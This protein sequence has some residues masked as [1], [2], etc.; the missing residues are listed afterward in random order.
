MNSESTRVGGGGILFENCQL[1][2]TSNRNVIE[3]LKFLQF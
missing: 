1:E 2:W 3:G